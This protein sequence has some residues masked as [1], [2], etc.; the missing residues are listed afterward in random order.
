MT[1]NPMPVDNAPQYQQDTCEVLPRALVVFS[2]QTELMWLRLFRPGFRHCFVLVESHA[3]GIPVW[4][5]YNPLSVGTQIALWPVNDAKALEKW[6]SGQGYIVAEA[7]VAPIRRHRFAWRPYTC[8][9]AVKRVIGVHG[10]GIWTPW[11]LYRYLKKIN[12]RKI[13]LDYTDAL[14]YNSH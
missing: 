10:A 7:V 12:N 3:S 8:V 4:I 5:L 1:I 2:G 13:I 6:F 14:G 9:E 11:Q